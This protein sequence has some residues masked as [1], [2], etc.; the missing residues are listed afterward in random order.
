[1]FNSDLV[2][3]ATFFEATAQCCA[4]LDRAGTETVALRGS[5]AARRTKARRKVVAK[6][7]HR[8]GAIPTADEILSK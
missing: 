1:M 4:V 8:Q 6:V 3:I 2:K 5:A 7:Q